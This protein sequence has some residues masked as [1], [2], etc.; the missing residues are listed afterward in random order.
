MGEIYASWKNTINTILIIDDHLFILMEECP[1][2]PPANASR[3]VREAYERWKRLRHDTLKYIFNACM[4]EGASIR[5]HVLNM[6]IYFNVAEM[7]GSSIDE[8][9]QGKEK[10]IEERFPDEL[11]MSVDINVPGMLDIVNFIV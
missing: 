9:N 7:N 11:L 1:L 6:M 4:Q 10:D 3:I 5:E 8:A 2:R